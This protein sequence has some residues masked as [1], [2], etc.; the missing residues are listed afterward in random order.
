[1]EIP[2]YTISALAGAQAIILQCVQNR[3]LLSLEPGSA[4]GTADIWNS[5]GAVCCLSARR[6]GVIRQRTTMAREIH[7]GLKLKRF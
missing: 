6:A 2:V 7:T 3:I 5:A 1:M 4:T